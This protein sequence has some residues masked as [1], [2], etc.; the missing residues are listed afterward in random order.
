M[1]LE[2]SV[3]LVHRGLHR[4]LTNEEIEIWVGIV[5]E[6]IISTWNEKSK[7]PISIISVITT[8]ENQVE[9][10]LENNND[11]NNRYRRDLI[12][13]RGP[14]EISY[15]QLI[16][17]G[18]LLPEFDG[19][20]GG[21]PLQDIIFVYPFQINGADYTE[22]IGLL[23]DNPGLIV[24]TSEVEEPPSEAP[25]LPPSARPTELPSSSPSRI[26]SVMP[27]NRPSRT[28]VMV[29][30]S[31]AGVAR[32][33]SGDNGDAGR[34]TLLILLV[35]VA[36]GL[37][38]AS[39]YIV[40]LLRKERVVDMNGRVMVIQR[41]HP[42][43][44]DLMVNG[45]HHHMHAL[46][47]YQQQYPELH[48]SSSDRFSIQPGYYVDTATIPSTPVPMSR[49]SSELRDD[50]IAISPADVGVMGV[51]VGGNGGGN[52]YNTDAPPPSQPRVPYAQRFLC[53]PQNRFLGRNS[54]QQQHQQQVAQQQ[55]EQQQQMPLPPPP[56]TLVSK[57]ASPPRETTQQAPLPQEQQVVQRSH[58]EPS[59]STG[60]TISKQ[61]MNASSTANMTVIEAVPFVEEDEENTTNDK[62]D[63][64]GAAASL[65]SNNGSLPTHQRSSSRGSSYDPNRVFELS[66][67]QMQV[68]DLDDL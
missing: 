51:P 5:N 38:G 9:F 66:G 47:Q 22:Q 68:Q 31:F 50:S 54:Q 40:Y 4:L 11:K 32:N 8:Y 56:P 49:T 58:R 24:V 36:L 44:P 10:P 26:P 43:R 57:Q 14:I 41:P 63:P 6:F 29:D 35:L 23:I 16:T 1:R 42:Q 64:R 13:S 48:A 25:S 34:T 3:N 19:T 53:L 46:A 33:G 52:V 21:T 55:Q 60:P 59:L 17:Y 27:S 61:L 62:R 2:A 28:P 30:P 18:I 12:G 15:N 39:V 67:F 7:T 45:G 37:V 65:H 20:V